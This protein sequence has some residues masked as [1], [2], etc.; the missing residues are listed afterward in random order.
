MPK[1]IPKSSAARSSIWW[2]LGASVRSS[3]SSSSACGLRFGEAAALGVGDVDVKGRRMQ[4]RRSV[5]FVTG[6]G[7]VLV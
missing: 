3:S 1:V 7:L 6:K 5:T 4:V 2:P